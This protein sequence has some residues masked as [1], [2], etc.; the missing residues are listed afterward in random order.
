MCSASRTS[1]GLARQEEMLLQAAAVGRRWVGSGTAA[2]THSSAIKEVCVKICP[3]SF[4]LRG[5]KKRKP[6]EACWNSDVPFFRSGPPWPWKCNLK[7]TSERDE[8][9][10]SWNDQKCCFS[11]LWSYNHCVV[12]SSPAFPGSLEV[13]HTLARCCWTLGPPEEPSVHQNGPSTGNSFQTFPAH[14]AA[15]RKP[16]ER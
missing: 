10:I 6:M 7:I 9:F 4:L 15:R 2:L 16:L 11:R 12:D 1:P 14:L 5:E 3:V 13:T 8:E